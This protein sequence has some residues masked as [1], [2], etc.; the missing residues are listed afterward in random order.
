MRKTVVFLGVFVSFFLAAQGGRASEKA[1][2]VTPEQALQ[3]LAEGNKRFVSEKLSNPHCDAQTRTHLAGGQT[4]FAIILGCS[5]SRVPPEVIF[6][7]GLGDLFVVRTAGNIVDDVVLGSIEY[8]A[9]HLGAT[10][11][12]VLG[13]E[14]CGAVKATAAGGEAPGHI[15]ALVRAIEPSV[16]KAKSLPGDLVDNAVNLNVEEM[17]RQIETSQPI[18]AKLIEEGK[19]KVVGGR[20]DLDTGEVEIK[21]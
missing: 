18:L 4:P 14:R 9:E 2:G 13:H 1:A 21:P 10:L 12:V 5:D 11:V 17:K 15:P 8:A 16:E 7:Q 3:K 19:V 6:D 20:Y